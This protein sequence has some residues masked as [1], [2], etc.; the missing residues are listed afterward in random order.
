[1]PIT[2]ETGKQTKPENK[3]LLASSTPGTCV[4]GLSSE[5]F[6]GKQS[7][8]IESK[9]SFPGDFQLEGNKDSNGT[10]Y[11]VFHVHT[12]GDEFLFGGGG[13]VRL[14]F[15]VHRPSKRM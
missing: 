3:Q 2:L 6:T 12:E 14:P 11:K 5:E 8:L 13:T 1:M 7:E 15:L 10:I 9:E 4:T